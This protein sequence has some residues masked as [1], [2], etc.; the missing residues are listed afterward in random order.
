MQRTLSPLCTYPSTARRRPE[1][2]KRL[3][4]ILRF[5]LGKPHSAAVTSRPD[6]L[7]DDSSEGEIRRYKQTNHQLRGGKKVTRKKKA[8]QS[9]LKRGMP[10]KGG[11]RGLVRLY[12]YTSIYARPCPRKVPTSSFSLR[13][14]GTTPPP[15]TPS[16]LKGSGSDK[17][18]ITPV[19]PRLKTP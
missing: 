1:I 8:F 2:R 16:K 12:Y 11:T 10:P 18:T 15:P 7:T 5:S 17:R 19:A 9:S 6:G 4:Y 13:Q 3:W 14:E